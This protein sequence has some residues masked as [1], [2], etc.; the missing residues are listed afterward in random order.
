V[1]V[2]AVV[3]GLCALFALAHAFPHDYKPAGDI[4]VQAFAALP[5]NFDGR[6]MPI[7]SMA[8]DALKIVS[9]RESIELADGTRVPAAEWLADVLAGGERAREYKVFRIDHLQIKSLLGFKDTDKLFSWNDIFD[10]SGNDT[11]LQ[12]EI[13]QIRKVDPKQRD[14]YQLK[15]V[16]LYEHLK[17]Y[18]RLSSA[19][20]VAELYDL[21][22]HPSEAQQLEEQVRTLLGSGAKAEQLT[23]EQRQA[24]EKYHRMTRQADRLDQYLSTPEGKKDDLYFARLDRPDESGQVWLGLGKAVIDFRATRRMPEA[25]RT[26][27]DLLNALRDNR[28]AD[29]NRALGAY[30]A[31]LDRSAPQDVNKAG[32]ELFF[33]RFDPFTNAVVLYVGVFLFACLS[34][35]GWPK[36]FG[37]TAWTLLA[38]AFLLHAFGLAARMYI[39]GRPP[40]TNLYSSALFIG[41]G[42]VVL[43]AGLE[44]VFRNRIGL[45]AAALIGFLPLLV[46][47]GIAFTDAVTRNQAD[48]MGQ[49]QA[50]LDTNFWLA[51]HVVI[52]TLGYA[53][54]FLAGLLAAVYVVGGVLTPAFDADLRKAMYRMV[55]GILCFAI[56]FSFVGTLLGGI[57]ADQ[58]WGRFW[59]WDP[60]ENGAAMIVL[61]N[62]VVLHAR[63]GGIVRERGFMLLAIVGNVMTAWS[64]FG[65]NMLGIGLHAYGFMESAPFYLGMFIAIQLALVGI[66]GLM[67]AR[68]WRSN[69]EPKG[70]ALAK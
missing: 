52:V 36:G 54:T 59:G 19:P 64:W 20:E 13:D 25:A 10:Q 40:V 4:N 61:W 62:A 43:C 38:V 47:N 21:V 8:R 34:W 15:V 42:G 66:G 45:A 55:Y 50:V 49:L 67:P 37:R 58:S 56:L 63:W 6:T 44:W 69:V 2:P 60:K 33:N 68:L 3:G 41:F 26:W 27:M 53:S 1:L 7:D 51:T 46:A 23:G 57:W 48:T 12:N 5:V 22:T 31:N 17:T 29:F 39:S 70:F 11:R 30:A 14:S 65:T 32:F 28:G 35:L 18:L 9:G 16:Q 24:L